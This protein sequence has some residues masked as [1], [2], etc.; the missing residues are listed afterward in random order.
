MKHVMMAWITTVTVKLI[1]MILPVPEIQPVRPNLPNLPN[2][3]KITVTEEAV[4]PILAAT[5]A[6]KEG[7][8]RL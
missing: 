8:M 6:E 2:L 1:V 7:V 5:I 3:V 4:K